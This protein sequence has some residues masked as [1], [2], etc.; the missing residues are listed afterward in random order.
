MFLKEMAVN[1]H[2]CEVNYC[3]RLENIYLFLARYRSPQ[4]ALLVYSTGS[5]KSFYIF[6]EPKSAQYWNESTLARTGSRNGY[7]ATGGEKS[8]KF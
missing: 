4:P 8:F 3:V 2:I 1:G 6:V 7:P 5:C